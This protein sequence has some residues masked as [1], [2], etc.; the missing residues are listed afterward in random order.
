MY[1]VHYVSPQ[2]AMECPV[3]F[4]Q[5]LGFV[6][7]CPDSCCIIRR[8]SGKRQIPVVIGSPCFPCHMHV[9]QLE[10][11]TCTF[12]DHIF[13]S[14]GKQKGCAFLKHALS[15]RLITQKYISFL[16][17]NLSIENR[18]H[19]G[20]SIGNGPIC[21]SQFQVAD[22]IGDTSQC[23]RLDHVQFFVQIR[24]SKL[25]QIFKSF[26]RGNIRKDLYRR[27]IVRTADSLTDRHRAVIPIV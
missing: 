5:F 10:P 27:Y 15:L 17:R 22:T 7:S 14:A 4:R 23:Q 13:H 18:L 9:F 2:S 1:T 6:I 16:V 3:G 8:I 21:R 25:L 19:I 24:K 20:A 26:L 11:C 12:R